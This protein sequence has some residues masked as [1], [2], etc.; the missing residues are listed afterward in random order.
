MLPLANVIELT[1]TLLPVPTFLLSKVEPTVCPNVSDPTNPL[2][3]K[4]VVAV[5]VPSYV[6]LAADAVAVKAFTATSAV[7]VE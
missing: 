3:V 5:V 6:L 7:I 4:V 1:V 2:K